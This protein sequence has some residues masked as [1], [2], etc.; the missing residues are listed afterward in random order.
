L[1]RLRLL[2][3]LAATCLIGASLAATA[4]AQVPVSFGTSWDGPSHELQTIVDGLYGTGVL[5]VHADYIGAKAGDPDPWFWVSSDLPVPAL[6]ITEVAGNANRNLLGWYLDTGMNHPSPPP[7]LFDDDVHDGVVFA[8]PAGHGA[9]AVVPVPP[10]MTKFGFYLNPNGNVGAT[11]APEPE[12]FW[13]NRFFN[14]IGP[15]GSGALHPPTDGDVQAL[16]FDLSKILGQPGTWLV[17]F[18]DLDSGA[19]PG[20]PATCQTDND[21]NDFVFEVTAL[22]ATPAAKLTFGELKNIYRH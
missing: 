12:K 18:E 16:V 17:C 11:N 3:A 9:M 14:D 6:L 1:T 5:D 20:P 4:H 7:V 2:S 15:D 13:T 10:G 8:G 19:I 22:G 21:F